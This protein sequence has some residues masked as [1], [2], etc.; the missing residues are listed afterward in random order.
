MTELASG[1]Y[2]C[3][4]HV[5]GKAISNAGVIDNGIETIIFDSF[6]SP[7]VAEELLTVIKRLGLSPIRYVVNSHAHNDHIRGNQVFPEDARIISTSQ[8]AALIEEWEPLQIA[9]EKEHAPAR[10]AY[11]DSLLQAFDGDTASREYRN[12]LMWH[13]YYAVLTDSYREVRTR[14]PDMFVDDEMS[15]NGPDR[16]VRL[17]S[18]GSGH[19]ESDLVVYLPDDR[20]IFSS[21][22]I[23]NDCHPYLADGSLGGLK[24]WLDYLASLDAIL[25]V[26]G[27]GDYGPAEIIVEMKDYV[28]SIE[29]LAEEMYE[30]GLSAEDARNIGVPEKFIHYD[31][32]RFFTMNLE[33]AL[34]V[35]AES[36]R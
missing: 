35:K 17:I 33:F 27:H 31:F 30:K 3:I 4:H 21:D 25:I 23:F 20:I 8:T 6:L 26:P 14:L 1:V 10:F 2:A 11:Y 29:R 9:Y 28:L 5:G 34:S 15:L 12:I 22:I 24:A 16:Q 13:P 18:R 19:S 32:D 7:D 36:T